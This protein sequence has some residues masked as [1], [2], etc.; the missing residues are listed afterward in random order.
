MHLYD[1]VCI[2]ILVVCSDL[3][4]TQCSVPIQYV[5]P[6]CTD[7]IQCIDLV[8][9]TVSIWYSDLLISYLPTILTHIFPYIRYYYSAT[10]AYTCTHV[11][12]CA[13]TLTYIPSALTVHTC[14][15]VLRR[16]STPTVSTAVW[17]RSYTYS[18]SGYSCDI[19]T[20]YV[21]SSRC[22]NHVA[23]CNPALLISYPSHTSSW[24]IAPECLRR[25]FHHVRAPCVPSSSHVLPCVS[26]RTL[27][28]G[29]NPCSTLV[30]PSVEVSGQNT[31][32][33]LVGISDA[34]SRRGITGFWFG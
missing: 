29:S 4:H 23:W 17:W 26:V 5:T 16:R 10:V 1:I 18:H 21:Y 12:S 11:C 25:S 7:L 2:N 8:Q 13:I 20:I 34:R 30:L 31:T 24:S 27:D 19:G 14:L 6:N 9:S 28:V 15:R 3:V 22:S 32:M 33:V